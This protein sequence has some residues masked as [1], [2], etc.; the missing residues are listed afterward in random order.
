MDVYIALRYPDIA[1]FKVFLWKVQG[2]IFIDEWNKDPSNKNNQLYLE[3][4]TIEQPEL[5]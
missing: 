2:E 5:V 4:N 1:V 3:C